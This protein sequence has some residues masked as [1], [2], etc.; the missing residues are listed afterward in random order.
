MG[1]VA[2]TQN[3][4]EYITPL[5]L[6]LAHSVILRAD[7]E[8]LVRRLLPGAIIPPGA[9]YIA[10]CFWSFLCVID[11]ECDLRCRIAIPKY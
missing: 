3:Y 5:T 9:R 6:S 4:I 11:G 7:S 10:T 8:D 2:I 1:Y